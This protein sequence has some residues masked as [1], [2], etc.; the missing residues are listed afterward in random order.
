LGESEHQGLI[1]EQCQAKTKKGK[2][3]RNMALAASQYCYR[4]QKDADE[5]SHAEPT[6]VSSKES[7]EKALWGRYFSN[8]PLT[9]LVAANAIPLF[10]VIFLGWDAFLIVLLYWAEN[11]V[12]GFYN[13]L[14][15]A[16]AAAPPQRGMPRAA[17]HL[18]K[19][20]LI[21]FF[22]IHYGGFTAVHGMFVLAMFKK[23][24]DKFM[25]GADWPC[26]LVFLQMLLN[27]IKRAYSAIPAN[28]KFA[29][30]A[31]F[32]SHGVS[33][34]Y[35]Y[36]LKREFATM[37]LEKQMMMPYARIFV[38]HIAIIA[39][40]ILVGALGSPAALLFVLVVLKTIL[41]AALHLLEHRKKTQMK[42][43]R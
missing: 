20:F 26:F 33:F 43:S 18:G 28:M 40:G 16:L 3:C 6:L 35:N 9:A 25:E 13:I 5:Q 23:T 36:L 42:P 32:I 27:V 15:M 19:L 29:L 12:V 10:G 14:K 34:V 11:L 31:L 8:I 1:M 17:A 22:I 24:E 2:R 41:D 7:F 39:G 37:K 38:M 4:H 30:L 21:P